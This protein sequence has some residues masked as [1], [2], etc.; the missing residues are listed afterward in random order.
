MKKILLLLFVTC[1]ANA[2][3]AQHGAKAPVR[4]DIEWLDV[5]IP[6]SNDEGLPRV[7]LI[8]NSITRG[9]NKEVENLL[10][11]KAYV[12][13]LSTSKSIGDPALLDEIKLVMSYFPFDV[14]HF[15]NG[16]HGWGYTEEAYKKAF[17]EFFETIRRNAPHAKYIWATTT[18]MFD[19]ASNMEKIDPK[20]ERVVERNKI[21]ASY[22]AGK[23]VVTN[24]LYTLAVNHPEYYAGGDGT[25]LVKAG[26]TAL[27]EQVATTILQVLDKK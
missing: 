11:G 25:H 24:D 16:L 9:Y 18:P 14:V 23:P 12:A 21:A 22:F 2:L 20:T 17:P 5:W 7:L 13:R 15:N 27:A 6:N 1:C 8:G 10:K 19:K 26:V 4:E 3:F